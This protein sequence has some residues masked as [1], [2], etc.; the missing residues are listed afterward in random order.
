MALIGLSFDREPYRNELCALPHEEAEA[1]RKL[2]KLNVEF[3]EY[4][5]ERKKFFD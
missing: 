3:D 4:Q 2:P 5:R 1:A